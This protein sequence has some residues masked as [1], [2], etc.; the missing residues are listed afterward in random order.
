VTIGVGAANLVDYVR[1]VTA[2]YRNSQ[3]DALYRIAAVFYLSQGAKEEEKEQ[4][5]KRRSIG[6]E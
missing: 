2:T 6:G 5:E 4:K 1:C 3:I